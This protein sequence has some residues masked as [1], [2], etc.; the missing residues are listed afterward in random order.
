MLRSFSC[1]ESTL[2]SYQMVG[3]FNIQSMALHFLVFTT[4]LPRAMMMAYFEFCQII[5]DY[6][7]LR[8][9]NRRPTPRHNGTDLQ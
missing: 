8:Q 3:Q 7:R 2:I 4:V 1:V 9:I 5:V 6:R